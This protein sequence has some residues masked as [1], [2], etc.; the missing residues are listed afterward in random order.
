VPYSKHNRLL[1]SAGIGAS[2]K[3][4]RERALR[5]QED[6]A[7]SLGM[8]ASSI[9]HIELGSDLRTSTLLRITSE[10]R[11]EIVIVSAEALPRVRAVIDDMRLKSKQAAGGAKRVN[12]TLFRK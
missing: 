7:V 2:L 1:E 12:S 11:L 9:S 3:A 10:L 5:S 8:S 4:A 6:L